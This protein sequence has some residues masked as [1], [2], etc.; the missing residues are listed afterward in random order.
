MITSDQAFSGLDLNSCRNLL[1]YLGPEL[2]KRVIPTLH[3]ALKPGAYLMLGG[4]EILGV[5]SD[6]FTLVDKKYKIYQ[7]KTT[8]ARLV[9]YFTGVNYSLRRRGDAKSAKIPPAARL[10]VEKEVEC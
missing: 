1:I 7:K 2:Q 3:Y 10:S 6:Y 8:S 4:A 5:F 9:T